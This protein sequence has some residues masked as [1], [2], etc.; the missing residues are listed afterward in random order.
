MR[1]R[2]ALILCATTVVKLHAE[3]AA[4]LQEFPFEYREGL[5]WIKVQGTK[6]V[7]PLNF[8]LDS[9]AGVSV[10]NLRT[11]QQLGLSLGN[12]VQVQGVGSVTSGYWPQ[13][14]AAKVGGISM[15]KDYLAVDLD[16][17][18]GACHC[19]VDGLLGA[20]FFRDRVVQIDFESQSV[21]LL[22]PGTPVPADEVLPLKKRRNA[23]LAPVK[24]NG[25]GPQWLRV[26]TG[27]ASALQWVTSTP[28]TETRSHRVAIAL[29]EVS[30]D[31]AA[32]TVTI[33]KTEIQSVSAE[34]H[35]QPIFPG[36]DGLLGNGI[37]S[38]FRSVT[39]DWRRGK[40]AF[41][42]IPRN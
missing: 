21:R 31:T 35:A 8:L 17:L 33:G 18:S 13:S 42:S 1:C 9:G 28:A 20:D 32:T 39:I 7:D 25:K 19:R 6:S 12:K 24:V 38:R 41:Q 34:L 5:L 14:F 15:P 22:A 10:L 37:L 27:C 23:L 3:R 4:C 2:L 36:E 40:I 16:K 26:D 30:L 11:A 29:R